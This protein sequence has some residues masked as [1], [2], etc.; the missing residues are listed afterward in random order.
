MICRL[1]TATSRHQDDP[2]YHN[3]LNHWGGR[4]WSSMQA[5][6]LRDEPLLIVSVLQLGGI[7]CSFLFCIL[8]ETV[9]PAPWAGES[10]PPP[11]Q[12]LKFPSLP[13][14]AQRLQTAG[15]GGT[16]GNE[17]PV[18][19][20]S[21]VSPSGRRA[22]TC[23]PTEAKCWILG[24][25]FLPFRFFKQLEERNARKRC[26]GRR[27]HLWLMEISKMIN[28]GSATAWPKKHSTKPDVMV[29]RLFFEHIQQ[30]NCGPLPGCQSRKSQNL[31]DFPQT[32][33]CSS[34]LVAVSF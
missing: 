8:W 2:I 29:T 22:C 25:P 23:A 20:P 16:P 13:R 4:C 11:C 26:C 17:H 33:K 3:F 10:L 6:S 19:D 30:I 5:Q 14:P 28:I 27:F 32:R 34:R 1:A 7:T 18:F 21:E 15:Q 31:L 24:S 9:S 12:P